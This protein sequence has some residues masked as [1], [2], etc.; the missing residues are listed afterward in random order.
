MTQVKASTKVG[1]SV[2]ALNAISVP[3]I[4]KEDKFIELAQKRVGRAMVAL[5][6]IGGLAVRRS[7]YTVEQSDKIVSALQGE[8]DAV[9]S[10]FTEKNTG[11][12]ILLEFGFC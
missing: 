5:R 1:A 10:A 6:S 11:I 4:S 3:K 12:L 7:A 2:S 9:Y 8:L